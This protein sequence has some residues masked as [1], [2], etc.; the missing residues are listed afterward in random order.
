MRINH[1][2]NTITIDL[3]SYTTAAITRYVQ[4]QIYPVYTP[5]ELGL[6]TLLATS[7]EKFIKAEEYKMAIGSLM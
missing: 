3:E 1:N 5:Q 7:E 4:G 6:K 2:N